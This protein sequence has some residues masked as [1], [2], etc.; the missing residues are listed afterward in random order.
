MMIQS[1]SPVHMD[2]QAGVHWQ[3]QKAEGLPLNTT[4]VRL[5]SWR[6]AGLK[7]CLGHLLVAGASCLLSL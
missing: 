4:G 3:R 6:A 2:W 7:A 1:N 5:V